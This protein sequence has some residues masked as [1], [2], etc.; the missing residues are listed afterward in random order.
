[1]ADKEVAATTLDDDGTMQNIINNGNSG[2]GG[3]S[4]NCGALSL[5]VFVG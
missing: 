1:V 4:A 5:G 2:S 3:S